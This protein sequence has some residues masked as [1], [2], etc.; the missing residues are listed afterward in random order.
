[1]RGQAVYLEGLLYA[2]S[3]LA[4]MEMRCTLARLIWYYDIAL[5]EGQEEPAYDHITISAGKLYVTLRPRHNL[6]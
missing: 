4:L 1:L 6:Y 5:M 2:E 3:R